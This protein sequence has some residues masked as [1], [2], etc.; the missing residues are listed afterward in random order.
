MKVVKLEIQTEN[1]SYQLTDKDGVIIAGVEGSISI[2]TNTLLEAV[3]K[4][5]EAIKEE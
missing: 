5:K 4:A 2:D 3:D 1:G